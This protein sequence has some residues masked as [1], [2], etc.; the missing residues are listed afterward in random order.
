MRLDRPFPEHLAEGFQL[1]ATDTAGLLRLCEVL[2]NLRE[3]AAFWQGLRAWVNRLGDCL[4]EKE[5][6]ANAEPS[7]F[8]LGRRRELRCIPETLRETL[9]A[10]KQE[11]VRW[12]PD[13][14]PPILS[15]GY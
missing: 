9:A 3:D 6:A 13:P 5:A 15:D 12:K 2:E 14:P 4:V 8:T 7:G 11:Y 10:V 1:N